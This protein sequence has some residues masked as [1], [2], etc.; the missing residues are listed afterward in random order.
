MATPVNREL[1]D[2]IVESGFERVL[3]IADIDG[4]VSFHWVSADAKTILGPW[5]P[6]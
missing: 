1:A 5:T 2:L 6:Q 3:A 4:N